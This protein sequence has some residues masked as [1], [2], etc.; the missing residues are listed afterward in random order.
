MLR[1]AADQMKIMIV[2]DHLE[3]RRLLRTALS[4]LANEFVECGAGAE[5]I[6]AF[7]QECPDWTIM[8]VAMKPMDGL[9][10]TRRLKAR[11]PDARILILT[12]HDLPAIRAAANDAG[13]SAFLSKNQLAQIERVLVTTQ[14]QTKP[15]EPNP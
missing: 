1:C 4:H 14:S 2:D 12:Q 7:E 8:D 9:E 6:A 10:A 15:S 11:F 13:A 3:M 5:A